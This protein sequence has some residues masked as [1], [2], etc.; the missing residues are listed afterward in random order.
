MAL[1]GPFLTALSISKSKPL[2]QD[3]L[4][5]CCGA[6][7]HPLQRLKPPLCYNILPGEPASN[8]AQ[9]AGTEQGSLV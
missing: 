5:S 4:P 3:P 1:G 7:L 2:C 8:S 9:A 6:Q